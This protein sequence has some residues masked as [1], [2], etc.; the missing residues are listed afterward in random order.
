MLRQRLEED[1]EQLLL[2]CESDPAAI[3]SLPLL[4]RVLQE[5]RSQAVQDLRL[6]FADD[7]IAVEPVVGLY[8]LHTRPLAQHLSVN[9]I[10]A[11]TLFTDLQ[12]LSLL[13]V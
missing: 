2:Q 7:C 10:V 13:N 11:S 9:L 5:S 6:A 8:V 1:G 3:H 12:S 4:S